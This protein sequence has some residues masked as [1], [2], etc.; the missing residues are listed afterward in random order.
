MTQIIQHPNFNRTIVDHDIALLKLDSPVTFNGAVRPI[1][2]PTRF[3]NYDFNNQT[4]VVTGKSWKTPP[5][6]S[7]V[8]SYCLCCKAG[9]QQVLEAPRRKVYL[10][11]LYQFYLPPFADWTRILAPKL[12]LICS[13]LMPITKTRVKEILEAHSIGLILPQV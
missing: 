6:F 9:E 12:R 3:I 2:L 8:I 7:C 5:I 1:C 13:A 10:R 4:G 11:F